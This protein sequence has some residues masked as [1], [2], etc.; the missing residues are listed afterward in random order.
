MLHCHNS[1]YILYAAHAADDAVQ[2]YCLHTKDMQKEQRE[3]EANITGS[4]MQ[5]SC[6]SAYLMYISAAVGSAAS[7]DKLCCCNN[8][9]SM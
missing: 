4:N 9:A 5:K 1:P 3:L 2:G 7:P 6:H 8:L